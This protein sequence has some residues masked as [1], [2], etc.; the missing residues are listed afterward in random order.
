M[1]CAVY[2]E[3]MNTPE[4]SVREVNGRIEAQQ[5][6]TFLEAHGIPANLRG[7]SL[8]ITHGFTLDGLGVV[9]VCVPGPQ[10]DEARQLLARADSGELTLPD[11]AEVEPSE[12]N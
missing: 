4:N 8:G 12:P 2:N 9:H 7:E 6:K 11:H 5:V 3:G 10:V 1:Q